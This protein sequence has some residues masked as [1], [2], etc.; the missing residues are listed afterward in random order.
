MNTRIAP[1]D[2]SDP[3]WEES[4]RVHDWKNYAN[5][6]LREVWSSLSDRQKKAVS[7]SLDDIASGEDWE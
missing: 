2:Y 5:D 4:V 1:Y 7:S 6:W 3:K